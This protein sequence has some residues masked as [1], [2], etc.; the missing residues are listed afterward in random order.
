MGV[1][2]SVT[3]VSMTVILNEKQE[4]GAGRKERL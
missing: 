4:T 3:N 2:M 1:R